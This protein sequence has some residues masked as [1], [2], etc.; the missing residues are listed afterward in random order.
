MSATLFMSGDPDDSDRDL[1]TE[2]WR[3]LC[4]QQDLIVDLVFDFEPFDGPMEIQ[5]E[6]RS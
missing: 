3:A 1:T 5:K 4:E 6:V 2:E